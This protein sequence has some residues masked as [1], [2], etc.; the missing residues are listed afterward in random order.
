MARYPYLKETILIMNKLTDAG[1]IN[2]LLN[3]LF[4]MHKI[5]YIR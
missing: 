2:R 1:V 5:K 4:T 3:L